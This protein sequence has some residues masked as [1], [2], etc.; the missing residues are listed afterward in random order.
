VTL[1]YAEA[2]H[3][4]SE[5]RMIQNGGKEEWRKRPSDVNRNL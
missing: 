3:V 4:A 5:D 2:G 1:S